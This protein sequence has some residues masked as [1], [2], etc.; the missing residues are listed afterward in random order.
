M[1][2]RGSFWLPFVRFTPLLNCGWK[3]N[4]KRVHGQWPLRIHCNNDREPPHFRLNRTTL[5]I[6]HTFVPASSWIYCA[7]NFFFFHFIYIFFLFSL[8]TWNAKHSE[9]QPDEETIVA[10]ST[11]FDSL[12]KFLWATRRVAS[13]R[14]IHYVRGSFHRNFNFFFLHTYT[15][16]L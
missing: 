1:C 6:C 7:N 11:I 14:G 12:S 2:R 13:V 10:I 16:I 3:K 15:H 4:K 8:Y 9:P 5:L